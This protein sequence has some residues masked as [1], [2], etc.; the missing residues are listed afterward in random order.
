MRAQGPEIISI[1]PGGA[2]QGTTIDAEIRGK[3]LEGAYGVWFE[4]D[5]LQGEIRGIE[6]IEL[7][8]TKG[9]E[10]EKVEVAQ[11]YRVFVKLRVDQ[12]ADG[13]VHSLR[14]VSSRGLSNPL[15]VQV[16]AEPTLVEGEAIL[17]SPLQARTVRLPVVI[18][19]RIRESGEVDR[20]AFD[21]VRGQRLLFQVFAENWPLPDNPPDNFPLL[22][23]YKRVESWFDRN[24]LVRLASNTE[25]IF[26]YPELSHVF[27]ESGSYLVEVGGVTRA[28]GEDYGY[29]LR[30]VAVNE[31]GVEDMK[32]WLNPPPAHS[33]SDWQERKFVRK[34]DSN[35]LKVLWSRTAQVSEKREK[36][37]PVPVAP[38]VTRVAEK[39]PNQGP[40]QALELLVPSI[41][42][43]AIQTPGDVDYFKFQVD[44]GQ[45]L[46]FEIEADQRPS[47]FN[48]R[49]S[50][51]DGDG[52]EIL[53]NIY[54][55]IGGDG[56]DWI[57]KLEPKVVYTFERGGDYHLQIRDLTARWG[58]PSF[59]YR[60][61]IRP[62]VPHVGQVLVGVLRWKQ[63]LPIP[64][65]E[66]RLNLVAGQARKLNVITD[67]EE[68]FDGEIIITVENLPPGVEVF[69]AAEVEPEIP[70]PLEA[71]HKERFRPKSQNVTLV[72]LPGSEIPATPIPRWAEVRVRPIVQGRPGRSVLARKIPVVVVR[73]SSRESQMAAYKP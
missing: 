34:I 44:E 56:D 8:A 37:E 9:Y 48:P 26:N 58:D 33:K 12:N 51:L 2:R 20:Y 54:R 35:R 57:K 42:E 23:V 72:L 17:K 62:Q 10:A 61:L 73:P 18:N 66:D 40:D 71:I 3:E 49:L 27:E 7:D 38:R 28:G 13:G 43:G 36:V 16:N 68:G 65:A 47:R 31:I 63:Q 32:G 39:E 15:A 52:E 41:I 6:K 50:V 14:L 67:Q 4:C 21:V 5:E 22:G 59:K 53:T 11:G 46:A 29:Q 25:T 55:V 60:V 69:P 24:R 70:P 19:G 1:F 45:K 64:V 30:I